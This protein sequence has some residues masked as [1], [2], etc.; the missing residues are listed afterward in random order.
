MKK[1]LV[2]KLAERLRNMKLK[3]KPHH[4]ISEPT[5]WKSLKSASD[6]L[7]EGLT[8]I[9]GP[10]C[11]VCVTSNEYLD[12]AIEIG[13]KH[14]AI[15]TTF[16]DMIKVPSSYSSLGREKSEGMDVR[17]VYSPWGAMPLADENPSRK[18]NSTRW[19]EPRAH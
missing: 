14:G 9:D 2:Q 17:I 1:E 11:P 18:V 13:R 5:P 6:P 8:L 19:F 12:R 4:G 10:G 15:I 7:P 16:G 3:L